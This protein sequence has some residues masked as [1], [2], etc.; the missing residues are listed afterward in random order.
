MFQ[1]YLLDTQNFQPNVFTSVIPGINDGVIRTAANAANGGL[2]T[3]GSI[4]VSLEP[5]PGLPTY[6][7]DPRAF[8]DV[9]MDFSGLFVINNE[10]GWYEGW[11]ISDLRVPPASLL[12]TNRPE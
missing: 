7:D 8:I 5:K 10:A 1:Y 11:M 12:I 6:P 3:I 9:F 2:P 4:R